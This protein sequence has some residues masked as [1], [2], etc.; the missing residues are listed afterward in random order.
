MDT[1]LK[2]WGMADF[3]RHPRQSLAGI[4]RKERTDG[5]PMTTVGIDLDGTGVR[6]TS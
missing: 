5:F 2:T 1:R 4:H 6:Y 3:F